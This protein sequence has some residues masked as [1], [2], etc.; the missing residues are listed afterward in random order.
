MDAG[1]GD[2]VRTNLAVQTIDP[3]PVYD[4]SSTVSGEK[5]AAGVER[6]RTDKVKQPKGIKTT[7]GASGSSAGGGAR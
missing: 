6:Y 3:D 2:S 7:S 1:F 4:N 5:M